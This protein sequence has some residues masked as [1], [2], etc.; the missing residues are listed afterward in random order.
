[1]FRTKHG[2]VIKKVWSKIVWSQNCGS[3][4]VN[5]LEKFLNARERFVCERF[6]SQGAQT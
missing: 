2:D 4:M 1:M 3:L 5:A 6:N